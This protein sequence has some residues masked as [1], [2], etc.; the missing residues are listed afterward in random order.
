MEPESNTN[1]DLSPEDAAK[2]EIESGTHKLETLLTAS[3]DR[4]FDK[5]ELYCM[6]NILTVQP[7]SL[8]PHVRLTHY[9]GLEFAADDDEGAEERPSVEGVTALRRR[10]HASQR[11]NLA[12]HREKARNE[13]LLRDLRQVLG[14]TA[15]GGVKREETEEGED[16]AD[17]GTFGF[18]AQGKTQLASAGSETPITTTT[19]FTLSQLQALRALS[20]SLRSLLPD[21]SSSSPSANDSSDDAESSGRK[22]WRK[23]RAGYVETS[24]R[25]YLENAGGLELGKQGEVRDG[26]YQG[27]GKGLSRAE[28]EGLESAVAMLERTRGQGAKDKPVATEG[29]AMDDS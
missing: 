11:L 13:T 3:I 15:P 21:L 8:R 12:L 22:T 29:G 1:N 7:P 23:E 20:T 2:L 4:N 19:Q 14:V 6:Q 10:L 26:E 16:A 27:E 24:S 9:A 28:V 5:L 18:L 17:N 25:K